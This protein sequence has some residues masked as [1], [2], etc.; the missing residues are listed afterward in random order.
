MAWNPISKQYNP[1][2]PE[3]VWIIDHGLDTS[4]PAIDCWVKLNPAVEEYTAIIPLETRV[5]D[6]NTVHISFSSPLLGTAKIY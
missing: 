1:D 2:I 6:N 5:V 4:V 3:A